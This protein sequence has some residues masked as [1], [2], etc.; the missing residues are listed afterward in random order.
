L[1]PSPSSGIVRQLV[2]ECGQGHPQLVVAV[3][4]VLPCPVWSCFPFADGK[5][6]ESLES[7][8]GG[9][10]VTNLILECL[11]S[12]DIS[13]NRHSRHSKNTSMYS[14]ELS[15]VFGV[16]GFVNRHSKDPRQSQVRLQT[17]LRS[18]RKSSKLYNE[19]PKEKTRVRR[20]SALCFGVTI[21]EARHS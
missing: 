19:T 18:K 17:E 10:G 9:F 4:V 20:I 15:S 8:G 6:L 1:F 2:K 12:D 7:G 5:V 21:Y 3:V 14:I 16:S 11:W 13:E